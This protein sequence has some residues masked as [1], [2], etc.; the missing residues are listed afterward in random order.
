MVRG[1]VETRVSCWDV[2][3]G[4]IVL[5]ETGD[6]LAADGLLLPGGQVR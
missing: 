3:V 4:D 2:L 6:I 1:G 5:L